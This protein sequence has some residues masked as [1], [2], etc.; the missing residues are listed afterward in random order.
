MRVTFPKDCCRCGLFG[1]A[2]I[3]V[4]ACVWDDQF[5]EKTSEK[6]RIFFFLNKRY[7]KLLICHSIIPPPSGLFHFEV[8]DISNCNFRSKSEIESQI[9]I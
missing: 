8:N 9:L 7:M 3:V 1:V 5:H 6:S 2:Y 4:G